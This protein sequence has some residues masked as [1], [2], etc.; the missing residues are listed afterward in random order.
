MVQKGNIINLLSVTNSELYLTKI[1]MIHSKIEN[2]FIEE[3]VSVKIID[4]V[5][6]L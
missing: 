1:S 2:V 6:N 5:L 3:Q 4:S